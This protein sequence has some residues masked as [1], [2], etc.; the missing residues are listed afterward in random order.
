MIGRPLSCQTVYIKA[1]RAD[2]TQRFDG[3]GV[4]VGVCAW[5]FQVTEFL[6]K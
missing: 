4:G 6:H 1:S 3:V 2:V 5:G